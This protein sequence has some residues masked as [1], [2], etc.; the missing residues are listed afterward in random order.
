[1]GEDDDD[2]DD[3]DDG[4]DGDDDDDGTVYFEKLKVFHKRNKKCFFFSAVPH[5]PFLSHG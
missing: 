1:M 2:D 3:D 4:D 5:R